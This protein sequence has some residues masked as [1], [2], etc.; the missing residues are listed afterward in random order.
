MARAP[1]ELE[2]AVD[3]ALREAFRAVEDQPPPAV[4]TEHVDRLAAPKRGPN[5]RS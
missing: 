2:K 1:K 4:L 5:G 3:E